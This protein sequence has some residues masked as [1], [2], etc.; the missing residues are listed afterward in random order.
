MDTPEEELELLQALALSA[1]RHL[2]KRLHDK[3]AADASAIKGKVAGR[4]E[5]R[6]RTDRIIQEIV[7]VQV[8]AS[9]FVEVY[10]HLNPSGRA[11]DEKL[12]ADVGVD[13]SGDEEKEEEF[14][15]DISAMSSGKRGEVD[16][17]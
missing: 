16:R 5:A 14:V 11:D 17:Q 1:K 12:V 4:K 7:N 15:V 2:Y 10:R 13:E 3:F 8:Q 9:E 6:W